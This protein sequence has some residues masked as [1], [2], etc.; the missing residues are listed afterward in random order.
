MKA[1]DLFASNDAVPTS[2]TVVRTFATAD[3]LEGAINFEM[4]R[5]IHEPDW[6]V[7]AEAS[8]AMRALIAQRTAA[9]VKRMEQAKG[10]AR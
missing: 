10:L 5:V 7:K 9:Q 4:Q 1:L 3:E 6:N 8:K 2:Q